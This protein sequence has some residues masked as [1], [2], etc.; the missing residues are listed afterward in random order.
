MAILSNDMVLVVLVLLVTHVNICHTQEFAEGDYNCDDT[1]NCSDV[2]NCIAQYSQLDSYILNN[3]DLL[4]KFTETFFK[5]GEGASQFVKLTYEFQIYD[6]GN[7]TE[8]D[9]INCT[10]SQTTYIWST[11][12]LYLLGPD[13]LFWLTLFAVIVPEASMTIELPCFCTDSYTDLL[14]RL[15]YLV[16]VLCSCMQYIRMYVYGCLHVANYVRS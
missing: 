14:E 2:T 9:V 6:E 3:K 10:S 13:P 5:T 15:T 1:G 11:S 7:S 12:V 4:R 8:D 16:W